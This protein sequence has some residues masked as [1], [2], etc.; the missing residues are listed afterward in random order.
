MNTK[1]L[2]LGFAILAFAL[3][4]PAFAGVMAFEGM[5]GEKLFIESAPK[6]GKAVHFIK[7]EGVESPWANKVIKVEKES[8]RSQR[9]SFEYEMELSS[10]IKKRS[11]QIVV[12]N[13]ETVLD[14]HFQGDSTSPVKLTYDRALTKESQKIDLQAQYN[15]DPFKPEVD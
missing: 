14:L 3:A 12:G 8:G 9:Y 5:A 2:Q 6:L 7:F 1:T 15:K 11:Y 13:S 4:L 10:G